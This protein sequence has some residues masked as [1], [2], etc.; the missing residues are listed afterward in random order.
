MIQIGDYVRQWI[1]LH[2]ITKTQDGRRPLLL[3][4][5]RK[6]CPCCEGLALFGEYRGLA[7]CEIINASLHTE[8][9]LR[10][11]HA[12]ADEGTTANMCKAGGEGCPLRPQNRKEKK[13]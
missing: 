10:D 8:D 11:V 12:F 1:K 6:S 2:I 3:P 13:A 5:G 4:A 7:L 9:L